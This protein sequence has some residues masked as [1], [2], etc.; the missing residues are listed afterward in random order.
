ML[1]QKNSSVVNK[2][3]FLWFFR[4]AFTHMVIPVYVIYLPFSQKPAGTFL[5]PLFLLIS[6]NL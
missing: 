1:I 5:I 4:K 3:T 6:D 2:Y